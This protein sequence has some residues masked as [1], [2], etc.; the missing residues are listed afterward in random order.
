MTPEID[1]QDLKG[2]TDRIEGG[3]ALKLKQSALR[4]QKLKTWK[5]RAFGFHSAFNLL[6]SKMTTM[7]NEL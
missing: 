7:P 1:V 6:Q 3:L 2:S 5:N 4:T